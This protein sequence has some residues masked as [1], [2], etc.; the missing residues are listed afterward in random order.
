MIRL[1]LIYDDDIYGQQDDGAEKHDG[2]DSRTLR[3]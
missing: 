3:K 1:M 2:D